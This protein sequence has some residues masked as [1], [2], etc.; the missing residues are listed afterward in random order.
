V[1]ILIAMRI[2]D[3][4]SLPIVVFVVALVVLAEITLSVER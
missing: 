3:V 2:Q 1:A 4:L